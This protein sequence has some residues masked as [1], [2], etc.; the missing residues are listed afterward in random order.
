VDD[1]SLSMPEGED[2][3]I[4]DDA[5]IQRRDVPSDALLAL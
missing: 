2:G 3:P 1:L 4:V 5:E